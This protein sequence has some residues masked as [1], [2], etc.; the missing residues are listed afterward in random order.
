MFNSNLVQPPHPKSLN[1]KGR[2]TLKM[3]HIFLE[4]ARIINHQ[5]S[6]INHQSSIINYQLSII[7][8]QLSIIN[9]Q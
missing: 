1:Q 4:P 3:Y 8:Y 7:N 9:C 6:I 2:G 5:S